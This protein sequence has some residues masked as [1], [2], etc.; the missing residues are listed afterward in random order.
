MTT[1]KIG[2]V[3]IEKAAALAPMAGVADRAFRELCKG[4]GASYMVSDMVSVTGLGMGSNKS[5]APLDLG[6]C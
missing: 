4:F 6:A 2:T 1:I 5:A 3:E